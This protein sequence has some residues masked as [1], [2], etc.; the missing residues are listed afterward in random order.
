MDLKTSSPNKT[1]LKPSMLSNAEISVLVSAAS[2]IIAPAWS[3]TSFVASNPLHGFE[4][5]PFKR[6]ISKAKNYFNAEHLPNEKMAAIA[7]EKGDLDLKILEKIAEKHVQDLT[8][9]QEINGKKISAKD[10]LLTAIK[11]KDSLSEQ[12][13]DEFIKLYAKKISH[14][15]S[16]ETS[17]K[18][19]CIEHKKD[20]DKELNKK[21]IKWLELFYDE[22]QASFNMPSRS[23]GIFRSWLHLATYE[24][25]H[26]PKT[27]MWLKNLNRDPRSAIVESLNALGVAEDDFEEYMRISLAQLNGWV[28]F[29]KWRMTYGHHSTMN[30]RIAPSLIDYLALRFAL[31]YIC[32]LENE[33]D[34]HQ[35]A[36]K[37]SPKFKEEKEYL[38]WIFIQLHKL[39]ISK[40][41]LAKQNSVSLANSLES[42]IELYQKKGLVILEALEESLDQNYRAM[43]SSSLASQGNKKTQRKD[44]QLVFCI[45]VR[46]EPFR[47]KL[48]L[49]GNYETFGFAGF[50]GIPIK[51]KAY[52]DDE[53]CDSCPVLIKPKHYIYE[54]LDP[55]QID[56]QIKRKTRLSFKASFNQALKDLKMNPAVPFSFAEATGA[57]YALRILLKSIGPHFYK[58]GQRFI[59]NLLNP[60]VEYQQKVNFDSH[61]HEASQAGISLKEQIGYAKQALQ[62]IGLV[63]NFAPIVVFCGHGSHTENNPYA[64]ALDC[65][66]CGGKHGGPNARVLAEILNNQQVQSALAKSGI[67][68]PADTV[69]V[70]AEH[71][72]TDDSVLLFDH[73]LNIDSDKKAELEAGLERAKK[74]NQDYRLA[75]FST[76]SHPNRRSHD[77]SETRPE[78]GLAGNANFIIAPRDLSMD[79]DLKGRS[80]LHSYRPEIDHDHKV[81]ETIMTA[82]MIV[83]QWINSQYFF[84]TV[85]NRHYGSGSKITHNVFGNIGVVQ[86]NASDLMHG[87]ALQ[88]VNASDSENYHQPL[89]ITNYIYAEPDAVKAIIEK[90]E[91]L[92]RLVYNSWIRIVVINPTDKSFYQLDDQK[93]FVKNNGIL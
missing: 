72:T 19:S 43:I 25:Y 81:L 23:R 55:S 33:A 78:W 13:S 40:Q 6:A 2:D 4:E 74:A 69:F 15:F 34:S 14:K 36:E 1:N 67:E 9:E 83:T 22:G 79:H 3:L 63:D 11:E 41:E 88:S 30:K 60:K 92:E 44:A 89:R 32:I 10:L 80:F 50:F 5:L 45:D 84:S 18:L 71:N 24:N 59:E 46:S 65:G 91:I 21:T 52:E 57:I 28:S 68:I 29:I 20:L 12:V 17:L 26:N 49:S 47:K 39:G 35:E 93:K 70:G 7:L 61:S 56:M 77:W 38:S 76:N 54:D 86:G 82:P 27:K 48:E 87:L 37:L 64:S 66:A 51:Y 16:Q 31:E 73:G 42:W 90:H 8:K 58:K 75:T 62:M 53:A 85:D